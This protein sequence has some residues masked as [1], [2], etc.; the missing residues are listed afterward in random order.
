[1]TALASFDGGAAIGIM[2]HIVVAE[3][4]KEALA[5]A[6]PAYDLWYA[7]LTKLQRENVNGPKIAGF[8]PPDLNSAIKAGSF[9]VG[10]PAHIRDEVAEHTDIL[11][12]NY[13]ICGFYFGNITHGDALRSLKL[14][15]EAIAPNFD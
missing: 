4:E 5:V 14:F 8:V 13:M 12:S 7:N 11:G 10:T 3:T 15:A 9:L 1:M 6:R 2:R